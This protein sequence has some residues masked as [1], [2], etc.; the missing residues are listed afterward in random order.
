MPLNTISSE[1]IDLSSVSGSVNA[2]RAS[3]EQSWEVV[4]NEF[5]GESVL[6]FNGN[7]DYEASGI[8]HF[9]SSVTQ[10]TDLINIINDTTLVPNYTMPIRFIGNP[11]HIIDDKHWKAFIF[12]GAYGTSSYTGIYN[13]NIFTDVYHKTLRPYSNIQAAKI[14]QYVPFGMIA[15]EI[16]PSYNFFIPEYQITTLN[17]AETTL[18]N[19]YIYD[20]IANSSLEDVGENVPESIMNIITQNGTVEENIGL[21]DITQILSPTRN[22]TMPPWESLY[23]GVDLDADGTDDTM[24]DRNFTFRNYLSASFPM[25]EEDSTYTSDGSALL[26]NI[27]FDDQAAIKYLKNNSYIS[28][29]KNLFPMHVEIKIPINHDRPA[30]YEPEEQK[31]FRNIFKQHNSVQPIMVSLQ[32]QLQIVGGNIP[33]SATIREQYYQANETTEN[34]DFI[35]QATTTTPITLDLNK[36]LFGAASRYESPDADTY[37]V[38]EPNFN[39]TS[40]ISSGLSYYRFYTHA[41]IMKT[42]A[43]VT[44]YLHDYYPIDKFETFEQFLEEANTSKYNETIAYRITKF[45]GNSLIQT[46]WVFNDSELNDAIN[47]ID[48][49]VGYNKVYTYNIHRYK[50]VIGYKYRYSDLVVTRQFADEVLTETG[51]TKYCL[52]FYNPKTDVASDQLLEESD[53]LSDTNEFITSNAQITDENRFLAD[54]RFSWEA[55]PIITETLIDSKVVHVLDNPAH[56]VNVSPY[57]FK[58]DN[59]MIGFN[60]KIDAFRN[61]QLPAALTESDEFLIETYKNSLDMVNGDMVTNASR[62]PINLIQVFRTT[63]MPRSMQDFGIFPYKEY[64][65]SINLPDMVQKFDSLVQCYDRISLH[66]KYYYVFRTVNVNSMPGPLSEIYEVELIKD[67]EH[68]YAVINT[69]NESDFTKDRTFVEPSL[70]MRKLLMLVPNYSQT[71]LDTS[72]LS[73]SEPAYTQIDNLKIG[74]SDL[75]DPL[76]NKEFKLRLTSKKT[77]KKI[78]L[79]ITYKIENE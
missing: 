10:N 48:T 43:E 22:A 74:T 67:A 77:G 42:M 11:D 51:T 55:Y 46:F 63:E 72:D 50:I 36:L 17:V 3:L 56:T 52:E 59:N 13:D 16:L 61:H 23:N 32:R 78:D 31:V 21:H 79:N 7:E 5:T 57:K 30:G 2:I 71:Q 58:N 40:A 62:S 35:R 19:I 33:F 18:P 20:I 29:N 4:T 39:R 44:K 47:F 25:I 14:D 41:N 1:F 8:H 68:V 45:V 66:K 12:G 9:I 37:F 69:L 28:N 64:D 70:S 60:V 54:F 49:Q 26:T 76:W 15:T 34:V 75:I 27:Y 53:E 6:E 65:L 38:G 73:Y 24:N